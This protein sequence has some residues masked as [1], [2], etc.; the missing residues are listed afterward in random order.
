MQVFKIFGVG[1]MGVAL[2]G[3]WLMIRYGFSW[4]YLLMLCIFGGIGWLMFKAAVD[5]EEENWRLMKDQ[6]KVKEINKEKELNDVADALVNVFGAK[7]ADNRIEQIN[8]I[9]VKKLE[10]WQCSSC[11]FVIEGET[12]PEECPTCHQKNTFFCKEASEQENLKK[13]NE[14]ED[15]D[16]WFE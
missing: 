2:Y 9:T 10:K 7:E 15:V 6:E 5:D 3:L 14:A 12:S 8:Q 13:I 11:G 4:G 1:L 16:S